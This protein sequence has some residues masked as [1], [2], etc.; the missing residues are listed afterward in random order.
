MSPRKSV[1]KEAGDDAGAVVLI[2]AWVP[3]EHL[4]PTGR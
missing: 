1:G 2:E 4:E 3:A